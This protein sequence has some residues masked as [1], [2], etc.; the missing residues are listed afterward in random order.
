MA[1]FDN[2]LIFLRTENS[3]S[4]IKDLAAILKKS[5]QRLKYSL[6]I[7]E[8]DLV[9]HNVHC[10]FDYSYFGLILFR[11]YFKG[12]YISEK[13]K[14]NIIKKLS[15]NP[16][17]VSV[18]ELTGEFDLVVEFESPNP[19]RFNKELKA[20]AELIPSLNNYKIVLNMVSHVYPRLYLVK[21]ETLKSLYASEIIVGGD[22]S[23]HFFDVNEMRVMKCILGN[24]NLRITTLAKKA[25]VSMKTANSVLKSLQ[26]KKIIK[27]FKYM[28][29]TN[30]LPIFKSRL[31]LRLHNISQDKEK[32]LTDYFLSTPE[33]IQLH[34]TVGDWDME[35]DIESFDKSR[36]RYLIVELREMFTPVIQA[37]NSI[38]FYQVYKKQYL[39]DY[40][41]EDET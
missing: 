16:Y 1:H 32:E 37:F 36:I 39:P 20:V 9:I 12:G 22:R 30:K 27:G 38:E 8:K 11:V 7:L 4:R 6:E 23:M 34:K 35:I 13:E 24:P 3:R 2:N 15:D 33:V 10:I 14:V 41:F 5:P 28:V 17:V 21:E 29:N 19:S 25:F 26:K 40:L 31:F 18:Y